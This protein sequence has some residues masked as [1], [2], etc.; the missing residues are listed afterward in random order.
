MN[1]FEW[2]ADNAEET[3]GFAERIAWLLQAGD[4][5]TLEGDLGAGKTTFTKGIAKGLGI[6]KT[7]NSPTFTIIKEYQGKLPLYHM[8]VYRLKDSDEDLG[9]DEYFEGEGVTVV[10][11]AH[12]IEEQL[13]VD[14][15]QINLYYDNTSGRKIVLSPKG[16]RYMQLCKELFS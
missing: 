13:P 7:V 9:F 4:V 2:K 3:I 1:N 15:L 11:W 8:D 12:L 14:Y 5:I 16:S 10:E 6:T